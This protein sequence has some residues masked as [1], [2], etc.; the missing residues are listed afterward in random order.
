M[1]APDKWDKHQPGLTGRLTRCVVVTPADGTDIEF[2]PRAISVGTAGNLV[3]WMKGQ[4]SSVTIAVQPGVLYP[5]A[6]DR[7]LATGHSAGTVLIYE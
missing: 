2:C 1:P 6:V 4:T 7:I 5:L 3:V